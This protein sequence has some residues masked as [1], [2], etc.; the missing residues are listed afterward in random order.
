M[1]S[2]KLYNTDGDK[3]SNYFTVPCY[4]NLSNY[5]LLTNQNSFILV[6]NQCIH[7]TGLV[8]NDKYNEMTVSYIVFV[9]FRFYGLFH[10]IKATSHTV[11]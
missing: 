2:E 11:R 5:N 1:Y 7:N 4:V 8:D 10:F 6:I 9:R 3:N